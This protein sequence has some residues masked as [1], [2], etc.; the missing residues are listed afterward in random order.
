MLAKLGLAKV[1]VGQIKTAWP[2]FV[3]PNKLFSQRSCHKS[4]MHNQIFHPLVGCSSGNLLTSLFKLSMESLQHGVLEN[5]CTQQKHMTPQSRVCVPPK[6]RNNT[7]QKEN[8]RNTHETTAKH[9]HICVSEKQEW[10]QKQ[11][12]ASEMMMVT[13]IWDTCEQHTLVIL[14]ERLPLRSGSSRRTDLFALFCS[15]TSKALGCGCCIALQHVRTTRFAELILPAQLGS[16]RFTMMAFG[17]AFAT[18]CTSSP[19]NKPM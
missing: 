15:W 14:L 19:H 7:P 12:P 2:N 4:S 8:E 5:M 10:F 9:I 13:P 6:P 3:W 17:S 16:P 1:D 18:C 11:S